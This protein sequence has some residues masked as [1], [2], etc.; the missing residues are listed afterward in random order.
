MSSSVRHAASTDAPVTTAL[1]ERV[2][3]GII[4]DDQVLAGPYGP[5][6]IIY[7]DYTA[8]GRSL[9]FI[10]EFIREQ[11]LP[12]YANTHTES[13]GTACRPAGCGRTPAG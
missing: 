11:V 13:S 4:G 1:L 7:A 3:R 12:R 2:R 5:R 8:S 9:D 10:E 6:R